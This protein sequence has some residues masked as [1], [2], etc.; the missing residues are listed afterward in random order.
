MREINLVV[1]KIKKK[2]NWVNKLYLASDLEMYSA[3]F[4]IE[5]LF[6]DA[7]Q[8]MGYTTVRSEILKKKLHFHWNAALTSVSLIKIAQ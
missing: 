3:R 7:K 8:H 1:T 6:R 2:G 5:F 4:Q